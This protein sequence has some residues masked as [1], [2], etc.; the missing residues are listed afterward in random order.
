MHCRKLLEFVRFERPWITFLNAWRRFGWFLLLYYLGRDDSDYAPTSEEHGDRAK[1]ETRGC[2]DF[3]YD[4]VTRKVAE[5]TPW[6][7]MRENSLTDLVTVR[8]CKGHRKV[9]KMLNKS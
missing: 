4:V 1:P 2:S 7:T 3:C 5:G 9:K 8:V 6:T